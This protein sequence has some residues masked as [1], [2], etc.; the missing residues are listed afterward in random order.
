LRKIILHKITKINRLGR[1]IW[2]LVWL[3]LYR[4]SPR[5][6]HLWRCFLLR[7][8]GAKIGKGTHPYPTAKI[9]APWNLE[10]ADH[11]CLSEY[12]DCYTVD[13]IY[14]G[15][16]AVVSQYTF[17]CTASHDYDDPEFPLISAPIK[18]GANAWVAADVYVGPGVTI[19]EGSVVGA[20]SS[21][22]KNIEAWTVVAGHPAKFIKDRKFSN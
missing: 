8:F 18:I 10:M 17:L 7:L 9:W 15:A 12:V 3:I 22:F 16:H 6:F 14:I 1:V 19:G 4:P 13:K 20:R 5:S 11:S 2:H 21:V